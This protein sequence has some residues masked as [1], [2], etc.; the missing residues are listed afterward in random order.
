MVDEASVVIVAKM[1]DE[2]SGKMA[3][4]SAT[5]QKTQANMQSLALTAVAVGGAL[6]ALGGL[7]GQ[8]DDPL[9]KTASKF[10]MI[11]SSLIQTAIAI[12]LIIPLLEG[13]AVATW[14]VNAAQTVWLA[15]Q[16]PRG[17]AILAGAGVA[18]AAT[19]GGMAVANRAPSD[20]V[21]NITQINNIRGSV[22]SEKEL[23]DISQKQLIKI[24]NRN[25]TSGVK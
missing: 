10:L 15:L 18:I 21:S 20:P 6:T 2:T 1:R 3:N 11:G 23:G 14:L 13:L 7:L 19:V 12:A 16:G 9:A 24:Q 8:M 17:W 4:L 5:T 25:S 22:I